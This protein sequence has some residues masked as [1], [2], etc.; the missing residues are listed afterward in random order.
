MYIKKLTLSH[1]GKFH[2]KEI[3][4][5]PGINI[6]YGE[7]EAGKSTIHSFIRGMLFGIE[8]ARGRAGKDD[9]YIK[10]QPL[11]T[12][13]SYEG[14]MEFAYKEEDYLIYRRFYQ[15]EKYTQLINLTLGKEIKNDEGRLISLFPELTESAYRNTVSIEQLRA[16]TDAELASEVRNYIAN[17]TTSKASEVDVNKAMNSLLE[18]KKG[19]DTKE[20][21][22][23]IEKAMEE[24]EEGFECERAIKEASSSLSE[25]LN[26][27][28]KIEQSY[29]LQMKNLQPFIE[30]GNNLPV[31]KQKYKWW[32]EL[33]EE[34]KQLIEKINTIT[35]Q[36]QFSN[37]S[38]V[39]KALEEDIRIL[40]ELIHEQNVLKGKQESEYPKRLD[41]KLKSRKIKLFATVSMLLGILLC[42]LPIGSEVIRIALGLGILIV[43]FV[44]LILSG[45]KL[46][47]GDETLL[48]EEEAF[49]LKIEYLEKKKREIFVKYRC[50][51][52]AI[53][54][55]YQKQISKEE[56]RNEHL[57]EQLT[58]YKETLRSKQSKLESL[59]DDIVVFTN[60]FY[61]CDGVSAEI[62]QQL[63]EEIKS[64]N[65]LMKEIKQEFESEKVSVAIQIDRLENLIMQ[66]QEKESA[67]VDKQREYEELLHL[68][69][70]QEFSLEAIRL[71]MDT[72]KELS[73]QIHDSFG[74]SLSKK[75][76]ENLYT[77]TSGKYK[78]VLVDEN[79]NIKILHEQ[80]YIPLEK[81]SIGAMEQVYFALRMAIGDLLFEG[82]SMPLVLD[83]SFAYYDDNRLKA[84][85][86]VLA[87]MKDRQIFIFTCHNREQRYL[88]EAGVPFNY[89]KL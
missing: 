38:K 41:I 74:I 75:V 50:D 10:Y 3:E 57:E 5:K 65:Q 6:I 2:K 33:Q 85:L 49:Q 4:C 40:E 71:T 64:K 47:Y 60:E 7:N 58:E 14:S 43:S 55:E 21:L 46:T 36:L 63:E 20:T 81:L 42:L 87:S 62:M 80:Q 45:K 84:V 51:D 23:L 52:I 30:K 48:K 27:K 37:N 86:Q 22:E 89:T 73:V 31:I 25:L 32:L 83:D 61:S 77:I 67:L 59:F 54:R 8:K 9:L 15:K 72:I 53:L 76:S 66:Y 24:I 17:L 78:E 34:S 69:E 68:K 1:F 19:I 70:E 11:D 56:I 13:G 12:P 29:L 18:K 26:Q 88:N 82:D 44:F 28:K 79:L 16:R 35:Q 39:S